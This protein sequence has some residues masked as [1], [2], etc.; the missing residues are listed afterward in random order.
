MLVHYLS[1][2]PMDPG[3]HFP[4]LVLTWVDF[5]HQ[6]REGETELLDLI[7]GGKID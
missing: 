1:N 7:L 6:G 3:Q 4:P 2:V 5:V